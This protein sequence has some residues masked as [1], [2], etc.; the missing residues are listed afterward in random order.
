MEFLSDVPS[1][2]D[3]KVEVNVDVDLSVR[4]FTRSESRVEFAYTYAETFSVSGKRLDIRISYLLTLKVKEGEIPHKNVLNAY[5]KNSGLL[6]VYPYIRHVVDMLKR[7][8]G[9]ILPPL[10]HKIIE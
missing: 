8:A 2:D 7:E 6:L 5:A 1:E 9:L 4:T 10:P 3:E